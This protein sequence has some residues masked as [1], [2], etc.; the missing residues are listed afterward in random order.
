VRIAHILRTAT[1]A[2]TIASIVVGGVA[3]ANHVDEV[4][5]YA[6]QSNSS[7]RFRGIDGYVRVSGTVM[8]DPL[9]H[10]HAGFI[11]LCQSASCTNWLQTGGIQGTAG[12]GSE[13]IRSINLVHMY[14]ESTNGCGEYTNT[15][16][17]VPPS[18]N[19]PYYIYYSGVSETRDCGTQRKF[20]FKVGSVNNPPSGFSW[21]STADGLAIA[22]QETT[23]FESVNTDW[24]GLDHNGT[25]NDSFGL[26]LK[27]SSNQWV[28]WNAAN[29]PGTITGS[30]GSLVYVPKKAWSAFQAHD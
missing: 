21:L 9:T 1:A 20:W 18:P 14:L 25:I 23:F 7:L 22:E 17:G 2:A 28:L 13:V 26:H 19:Y 30:N 6:A 4:H 12:F 3:E 10:F 5:H 8:Q 24:F 11:N 27:N 15:D 29:A 16:L